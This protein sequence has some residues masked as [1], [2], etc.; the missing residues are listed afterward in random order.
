MGADRIVLALTLWL[1]GASA[2]FAEYPE[3]ADPP[4]VAVPGRRRASW[5]RTLTSFTDFSA[6]ASPQVRDGGRNRAQPAAFWPEDRCCGNLTPDPPLS[7]AI[8]VH[9]FGPLFG[10][11]PR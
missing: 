3:R 11:L 7:P 1:V 6:S 2:T 9:Y 5:C 8:L 4:A 10:L